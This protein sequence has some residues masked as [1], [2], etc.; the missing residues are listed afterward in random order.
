LRL[1]HGCAPYRGDGVTEAR[2]EGG[3]Q[4][5]LERLTALLQNSAGLPM[6]ALIERVYKAVV[7]H[8]KELDDDVT[9]LAFRMLQPATKSLR[10][11]GNARRV[12]QPVDG[13]V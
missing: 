2:A 1:P 11:L 13:D 7:T 10:T 12:T 8:A 4:F 6:T 3:E 9:L 5:G